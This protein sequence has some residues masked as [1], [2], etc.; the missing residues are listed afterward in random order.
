MNTMLS[1]FH[2]ITLKFNITILAY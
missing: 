1:K 2:T